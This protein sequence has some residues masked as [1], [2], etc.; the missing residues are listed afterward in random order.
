MQ[1]EQNMGGRTIDIGQ[2][3]FNIFGLLY[4]LFAA[5]NI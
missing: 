3:I 2:V 5:N 4:D 1:G